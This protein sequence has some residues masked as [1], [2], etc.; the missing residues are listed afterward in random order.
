MMSPISRDEC[1]KA[2]KENLDAQDLDFVTACSKV[3]MTCPPEED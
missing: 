3:A 2:A 1:I